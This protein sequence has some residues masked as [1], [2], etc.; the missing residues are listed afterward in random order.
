MLKYLG[1]I[2]LAVIL[3]SSLFI[4]YS[5]AKMDDG[6]GAA[7]KIESQHFTIYY[8]PELNP[9]EL[10]QELGIHPLDKIITG[11]FYQNDLGGMIDTLFSQVCDILDMQLYSF[12]GTIKICRDFKQVSGIYKNLFDRGLTDRHS[13]YVYGLNTV[14]VSAE[15]FKREILGHEIAHAVETYYFAVSPSV[16][17]QEVLAGF[18]EYQL[19]KSYK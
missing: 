19:R 15:H 8:A 17:I 1:R 13:Y 11:S 3:V 14:Y 7:K 5:F 10:A 9:D 18:V 16:K 2:S 12:H 4:G 6:F